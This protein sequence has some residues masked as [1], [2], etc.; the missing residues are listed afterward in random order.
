ME[1]IDLIGFTGGGTNSARHTPSRVYT[2]RDACALQWGSSFYRLQ[3]TQTHARASPWPA[4]HTDTQQLGKLWF[5]ALV[6][7]QWGTLKPDSCFG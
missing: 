4:P 3:H 7:W 1:C 5:G 2:S 6:C